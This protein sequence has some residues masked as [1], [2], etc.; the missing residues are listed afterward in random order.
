[1]TRHF[2]RYTLSSQACYNDVMIIK[3]EIQLIA[4][5]AAVVAFDIA[6][7][8]TTLTA[9]EQAFTNFIVAYPTSSLVDEAYYYIARSVHERAKLAQSSLDPITAASGPTVYRGAQ[10]IL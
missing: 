7:D 2:I 1:M 5:N 8:A 4:F 9:A 10:Q 6:T 3:S